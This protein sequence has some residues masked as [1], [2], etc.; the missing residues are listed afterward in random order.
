V[1]NKKQQHSTRITFTIHLRPTQKRLTNY[2]VKCLKKIQLK[3]TEHQQ[4]TPLNF[5]NAQNATKK[6]PPLNK[7]HLIVAIFHGSHPYHSE[8]IIINLQ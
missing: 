5:E 3:I 7:D 8:F 2:F 6:N 1:K 4:I